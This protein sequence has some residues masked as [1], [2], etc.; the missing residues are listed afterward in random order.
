MEPAAPKGLLTRSFSGA[1]DEIRTRDPHLG[2]V[3]GSFRPARSST[4]ET[5]PVRLIF[6]PVPLSP[7]R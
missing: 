2:N 3:V 7:C 1:D 6:R 4:Q 5:V